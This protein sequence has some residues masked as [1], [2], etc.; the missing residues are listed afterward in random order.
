MIKGIPVCGGIAIGPLLVYHVEELQVQ[1]LTLP[2]HRLAAELER[3]SAAVEQAGRELNQLKGRLQGA[4]GAD[5]TA[6]VFDAQLLMLEDPL[7]ITGASELMR[8]QK[9]NAEWAVHQ[10]MEDLAGQFNS[11]AD[12]YFR[13]RLA[14][15]ADVGRRVMHVLQ[16]KQRPDLA[17]LAEPVIL[18]AREL[19]PS[20]LAAVPTD[21]LAGI[22]TEDG[23][24]TSHTAIMA[25]ARGIPVL[26][27][28]VGVI[29][30]AHNGATAVLDAHEGRLIINPPAKALAA[31]RAQR[32]RLARA[33]EAQRLAA[34]RPAA[35][36][37]GVAVTVWGN[38]DTPAE[39]PA[40][41]ASGGDGVGLFRSEYLFLQPAGIPDEESQYRTYAGLVRSLDGRPAVIR[42][43]DL[44]GD[45]LLDLG[46]EPEAN[47]FL[48]V[49]AI[50]LGFAHRQLLRDQLCAI[51]RAA[52]EGDVRLL[53]PMVSAVEEVRRVR[54][55][56]G[57][58]AND[59][60][61]RGLPHRKNLPVGAMVEIPAAAIALDT[62]IGDVDFVSVGTNDLVQYTLAAE[63]GNREM[64]EY[65]QPLHP[66][67][68]RLLAATARLARNAKKPVSVCG[69]L[70]WEPVFVAFFLGL[71]IDCLS[72]GATNIP[73]VKLL[74]GALS[75]AECRKHVD[76][77]L[78][79][80]STRAAVHY[81][82]RVLVPRLHRLLP[83]LQCAGSVC[84]LPAAT[85]P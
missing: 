32:E 85:N 47:P 38:I 40:L 16:E 20:D 42:T 27:G 24:T 61:R 5:A 30:R 43:F 8:S 65:Y 26:V 67:V 4:D 66:A 70:A 2:D 33:A 41:L 52:A 25:R 11:I 37:D 21:R 58:C 19:L 39:V 53:L 35:T 6:A 46:R 45:K 15:I 49:R 78:A 81:A 9:V 71:G 80:A 36:R 18:V 13:E 3:F 51:L 28:A 62:I 76:E 17:N 44:G 69:E 23:A 73:A 72:L 10:V 82:G 77:L 75:V 48:G 83:G 54:K 60:A 59:L 63:R 1:R 74:V 7:F 84:R 79:Q 50:R 56:I 55:I 12:E 29:G 22:V 34:R 64:A 31:Y 57:E 14:D 68:L